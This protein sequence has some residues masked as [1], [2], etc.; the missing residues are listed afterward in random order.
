M[1]ESSQFT[2]SHKEVAEALVKQQGIHKGVWGIL[3]KFGISGANIGVN[4]S[5]LVPAAVVPVLEIGLRVFDE[6]NSLSVDAAKVNPRPQGRGG[7]KTAKPKRRA[8]R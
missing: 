1:A 7:K 4:D 5:T 3:V 2:F 8:P 6:E